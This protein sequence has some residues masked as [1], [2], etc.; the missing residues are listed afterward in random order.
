M[1]VKFVDCFWTDCGCNGRAASCVY[2]A[3]K[4]YGVCQDCTENT[5]GDKCEHCNDNFFRNPFT[6]PANNDTCVGKFTTID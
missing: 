1:Q 5:A 3:V 4:E 2:D 6:D